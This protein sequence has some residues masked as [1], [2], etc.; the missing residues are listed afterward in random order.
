MYCPVCRES[1][2]V[3]ER[4]GIELDWCLKCRGLWFDEGELELLAEKSGRRL[5]PEDVGHPRAGAGVEEKPAPRRKCPRCR[6]KME[7][8]AAG[9]ADPVQVDRCADHGVWLDSGELGRMM[10]QLE[11]GGSSDEAVIL[12]FLGETFGNDPASQGGT[13]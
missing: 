3:V 9:S 11:P 2:V 4:E 6:R 12:R 5:G 8:V 10:A 13:R 1:L 7:R